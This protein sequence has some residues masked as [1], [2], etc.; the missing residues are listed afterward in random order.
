[1]YE[2]MSGYKRM[3][4]QHQKALVQLEVKCRQELE[5][6]RQ[7]LEKEYDNLLQSFSKELEK[8]QEG[9]HQELSKKNKQN[10]AGEKKLSKTIAEAQQEEQKRFQAKQR[11]E[12]KFIKA[13]LKREFASDP[14]SLKNN[15]QTLNHSQA[16][17]F[18]RLQTEQADFMR[19][20]LRKYRR[21]KLSQYHQF[22]RDLLRE[23]LNKRQGQLDQAHA[24][25]LRHHEVTQEIEYRQQRSIHSLREDHL[26]KQH[27]TE[28]ANQQDYNA[29]RENE[30]R[31]KHALEL[32]AQP[33]SLKEK[34]LQI[35]RQFRE[36]CK[37]QT[38]QYKA[39][40]TQI[41]ASTPREDQKS[42]IKK[43]KDEQMRK[44]AHLGEQYEQS[45]A[46]MLQ[47]Q[48]VS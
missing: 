38:R 18:N 33:K 27:H 23:E 8:L 42:V 32:K 29:R 3:R 45:I 17:A 44:L 46:E 37:I 13:R 31:K 12:Y 4:R 43:L 41:L 1:M 15:K 24:M 5:D 19:I 34:E 26:R 30:L 10:I 22:E 47:K 14:E 20:E 7:K 40:K 16:A 36:T 11:D 6:H 48:S 25:L 21:R 35:R 2:Q 28:L 9:N 39:W